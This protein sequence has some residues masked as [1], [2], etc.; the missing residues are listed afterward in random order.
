MIDVLPEC[1]KDWQETANRL[2]DWNREQ[3]YKVT[4]LE[5]KITVL[6]TPQCATCWYGSEMND[7]S[8]GI[9]CRRYAPGPNGDSVKGPKYFC[10]DYKPDIEKWRKL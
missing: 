4:E 7:G 9:H 10:G 5:S 3:S 8:Y 6:T 1:D 2:D